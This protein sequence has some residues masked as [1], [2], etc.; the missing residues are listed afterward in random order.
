MVEDTTR[1]LRLAGLAV[2]GVAVG[3]AGPRETD[4][5]DPGTA[6][7]ADSTSLDGTLRTQDVA[8]VTSPATG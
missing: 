7:Q 6:S 4:G 1:L 2:V 8:R 3:R 5:S